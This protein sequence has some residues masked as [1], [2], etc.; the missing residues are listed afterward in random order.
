[1][2]NLYLMQALY[3]PKP[4]LPTP[5][6]EVPALDRDEV[7]P[8]NQ[9]AANEPAIHDARRKLMESEGKDSKRLFPSPLTLERIA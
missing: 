1:M 5:T 4:P 2:A 8:R 7:H 9:T 6:P 3:D